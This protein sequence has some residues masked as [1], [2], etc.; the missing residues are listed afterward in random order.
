MVLIENAQLQ[1][2]NTWFLINIKHQVYFITVIDKCSF[3]VG[4]ESVLVVWFGA[5]TFLLGAEGLEEIC[6]LETVV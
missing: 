2:Y 1:T 5:G 6:W 3:L 4:E